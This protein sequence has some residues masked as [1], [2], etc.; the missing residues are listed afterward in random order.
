M[1]AG[2]WR[3][4]DIEGHGRLDYLPADVAAQLSKEAPAALLSRQSIGQ[5]PGRA[6]GG[7]LTSG[8]QGGG[9]NIL[10][11]RRTAKA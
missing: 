8:L 6:Q 4:G 10:A 11:N 3:N 9:R 2:R 1:W 7:A 5:Q